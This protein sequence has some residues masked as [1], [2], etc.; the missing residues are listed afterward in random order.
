[1][2]ILL[3]FNMKGQCLNTTYWTIHLFFCSLESCHST[4][5]L[6]PPDATGRAQH[7][8]VPTTSSY[9]PSSLSFRQPHFFFFF[10]FFKSLLNLLQYC[11]CFM[12]WFFGHEACGIF[13]PQ[14]GIEPTP[15]A[16]EGEVLTARPPGKSL[17][18]PSWTRP[19]F[20]VSSLHILFPQFSAWL[21]PS[22]HSG[23]SSNATSSET[24]FPEQLVHPTLSHSLPLPFRVFFKALT[25]NWDDLIS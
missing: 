22:C 10:S 6:V 24:P 7:D 14:P 15:P 18:R 20:S 21:P 5:A 13:A 17:H 11:F 9:F 2:G 23:F 25:I 12:F 4:S 1:M 19:T 8:L 3:I 16:L